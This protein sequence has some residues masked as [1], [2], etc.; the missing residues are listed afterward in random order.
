MNITKYRIMNIK[1]SIGLLVFSIIFVSCEDYLKEEPPTFISTTNFYKTASDARTAC[2][3]AYK[4][5]N[6]GSSNST[7]GR[8]WPVIDLA[9]DD[10]TSRMQ[11]YLFNDFLTHTVSSTD[12]WFENFGQFSNF[13]IGISRANNVIAYVPQIDM[14]EAERNAIIGEARALRALYYYHLVRAYGDMPIVIKAVNTEADFNKPRSS[15]DE[16]YDQ[17]IIPD[18]QYAETVCKD[19]MHS[20]RITKWTAKVILADVYL[21][22]AGWRRTSQGDLVQGDVSNWVL[23]RDKAKEIIDNSPHDLNLTSITNGQNITPAYGVAWLESAPFSKESMFELAAVPVEGLGSWLG[24]ECSP[25]P[26]GTGFWGASAGVRPFATQGNTDRILDMR[27]PGRPPAQGGF[28]PT[29][30]LYN[31]F[32]DGDERRDWSLMTRYT[33]S[34]GDLFLSQPTFRKYVDINYFLGD[35]GTSFRNTNNNFILYRFADALLIYAEAANEAE[36]APSSEA[37]NALNRIRNRAGL[38]N[39]SGLSQD[40]FRKLVANER[41]CEF[42]AECKRRFDLIRTNQLVQQ[43]SKITL[44]WTGQQD[45]A[46]DYKNSFSQFTGTQMW[47]DNEWLLPIP[48][49]EIELN[50]VNG[51]SQNKGY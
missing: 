36:G 35:E 6:D 24:R 33:T 18:L 49:S 20:G 23:A 32:E 10:V 42:N 5:F 51:W 19:Q 7:Y 41:R 4:S 50:Q 38:A 14:D 39:A 43:T 30:D 40:A 26:F 15:V 44:T 34:S 12:S 28:I 29:P 3:G 2:D 16:I 17:I 9:T 13:W 22:R 47:P 21:N 45:S 37:F 1:N 25:S 8:F 48:Q 11:G 46:T 31:A 27:F